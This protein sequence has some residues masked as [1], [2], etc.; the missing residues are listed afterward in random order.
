MRLLG[1]VI[2]IPNYG[3]LLWWKI[4]LSLFYQLTRA[5]YYPASS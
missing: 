4:L 5:H 3:Y 1:I 2:G